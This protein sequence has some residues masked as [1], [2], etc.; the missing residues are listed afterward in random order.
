M[1]SAVK[2]TTEP[3]LS[4][5]LIYVFP[6]AH[7]VHRSYRQRKGSNELELASCANLSRLGTLVVTSTPKGKIGSHSIQLIKE[8]ERAHDE[9][10]VSEPRL[11]GLLGKFLRKRHAD[12]K[13]D[14]GDA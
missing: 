12:K 5:S 2:Q 4:S 1:L 6:R 8:D 13:A 14:D 7:G 11:E 9:D 3:N 10:E